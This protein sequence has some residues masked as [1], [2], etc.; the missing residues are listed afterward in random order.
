MEDARPLAVFVTLEDPTDHEIDDHLCQPFFAQHGW[1]LQSW[2]WTQEHPWQQAQLLILRSCYDYWSMPQRFETFLAEREREQTPLINPVALVRWNANKRYLAQVEEFGVAVVP[3]LTWTAQSTA[4]ELRRF[5][6]GYPHGSEF[7]VKPLVGSGGFAMEKL[8]GAELDAQRLAH[9]VLVQP[10]LPQIASGEWS[11]IYFNG[12]ASHA[13]VKQARA[14][15]Y[16]VQDSHGGIT[17]AASFSEQP[18][19]QRHAERVMRAMR[20]LR[21][22]APCYARYDFVRGAQAGELWLMEVELIEP[23]LFLKHD[24]NAAQRF[25]E[26][27]LSYSRQR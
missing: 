27:L 7:V 22:P 17:R 1:R 8:P 2:A 15:E 25:V 26:A 21:L 9:D 13:V 18:E 4:E 23:T 6:A 24:S 10:F 11:A 16:R 5:V 3:S 19:L 14:G 20:A 12:V